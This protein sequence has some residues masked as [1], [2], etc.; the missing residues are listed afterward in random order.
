MGKEFFIGIALQHTQGRFYLQ[1]LLS[2]VGKIE[3]T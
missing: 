2:K 3:I 1:Y